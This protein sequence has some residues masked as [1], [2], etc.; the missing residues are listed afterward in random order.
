ME[1]YSTLL[2]HIEQF[3]TAKREEE[4]NSDNSNWNTE[5][6]K[7]FLTADI[8]FRKAAALVGFEYPEAL[9]TGS[10]DNQMGEIC[11]RYDDVVSGWKTRILAFE[12]EAQATLEY[13]ATSDELSE[14]IVF[15]TEHRT[16]IHEIISRLR[17]EVYKSQ[18]LG[19][20][21][22]QRVLRA[23]NSVQAEVDKERSNFHLILG[24]VVDIGESLG[25][26]GTKAK[27]AFDRVEQ[28]ANAIRGQRRQATAIEKDDDPLQIEDKSDEI[29][30]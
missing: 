26:A 14:A 10:H 11:K 27:P 15:D 6:Y 13:E 12:L 7:A 23:I 2:K 17:D 18:W 1:H 24:K 8:R 21:R 30:E 22:K 4:Q 20:E 19:D 28:L 16:G 25:Q 3:E 29:E 9:P 5:Y